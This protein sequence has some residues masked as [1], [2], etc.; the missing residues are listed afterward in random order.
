MQLP[1]LDACRKRRLNLGG[2]SNE[3]AKAG[4]LWG[5]FLLTGHIL[6]VIKCSPSPEMM[7]SPYEQNSLRQDAKPNYIIYPL[8]LFLYDSL[9]LNCFTQEFIIRPGDV[10]LCLIFIKFYLSFLK[11]KGN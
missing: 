10:Y 2:P 11:N 6:G 1:L 7:T 9:P 3:T 5:P 4:T 8:V